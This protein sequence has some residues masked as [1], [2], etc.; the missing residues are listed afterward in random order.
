M[1]QPILSLIHDE[2]REVGSIDIARY[3]ELALYH[4]EHGYYMTRDPFGVQG[5][6]TTAPE[7][8]QIYGE[9]I[10][11]WVAD[12]WMQMGSPRQCQIVECGAGRGTMMADI[13]RATRHVTGFHDLVQIRVI[14]CSPHLKSIQRKTLQDYEVQWLDDI[15][16]IEQTPC[17][18]IGNEFLDAL[19]LRQYIWRAQGWME[20][21]I[22]L[23]ENNDLAWIEEPAEDIPSQIKNSKRVKMNTYYEVSEAQNRFIEN[24]AAKMKS[25]K[26]ALLLIDYGYTGVSGGDT[27]QSLKNHEFCDPLSF[28]GQADIT[29][30]VNFDAVQEQAEHHGLTVHGIVTQGA[31]LKSLGIDLR[32]RKLGASAVHTMGQ[33]KAKETLEKLETAQKRLVHPDEMGSLFKL[34]T[35]S[36][37][38]DFRPAGF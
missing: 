36:Y 24:C 13:L 37:G 18:I 17:I 3:M 31:F 19:P 34:I 16:Q 12:C 23:S 30:H 5:D 6:F 21:R 2:I 29:A 28:T 7:I 9:L 27:L 10:G 25:N 26:G 8:S 20:R 11:A 15:S 22:A 14:E 32:T 35:A 33:E 4:P 1:H 38:F